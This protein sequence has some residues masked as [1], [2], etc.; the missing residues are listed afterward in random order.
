[1]QESQL[2]SRQKLLFFNKDYI[3]E[4]V[5]GG[6]D[7]AI[8]TFAVVAGSEG[9]NLGIQVVVILGLAN[10]IADGFSMSV[11]NFFSTKAERDTFD[12][13]KQVEYWEIEHLRDKEI[14][15][16]REIYAAKG[17]KGDLLE[18]V[19]EVITADKDVWV[20]TMMKEELE[21]VKSD[22]APYKTAGMTFFSFIIVGSVPLLS[23]VFTGTGS[24]IRED[25]F[26]YSCIL[27]AVALS[28]VGSLKSIVTEKNVI[29]G[30]F[31]TLVLG[32]L[33][34]FLAYFVG[35]VLEKMFL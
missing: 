17:F 12:R 14:Q 21:M 34:A 24:V 28:I 30:I 10:L 16:I 26:L 6:I 9:A 33:A 22:K 25:L 4:F 29:I 35:D 19:V 3:S 11:G 18:Q 15:E 32:G 13:H 23:Y 7:G 1:M 20:D 31:E 2:H 5:Y 8:T 27:T